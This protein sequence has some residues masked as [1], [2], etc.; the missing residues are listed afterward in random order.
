MGNWKGTNFFYTL[1]QFCASSPWQCLLPYS[2]ISIENFDLM[3][4]IDIILIILT[5]V[6][7]IGFGTMFI[8][9]VR[10]IMESKNTGSKNN[11]DQP[12]TSKPL[13][14]V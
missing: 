10:R 12:P 5:V 2:Y 4:A 6:T 7:T 13:P 1:F 9:V 14:E 3:E 11:I 8:I